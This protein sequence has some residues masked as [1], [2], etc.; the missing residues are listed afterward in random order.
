ML[1]PDYVDYAELRRA[2][3]SWRSAL[4]QRNA[5]AYISS[6]A[7][8]FAPD[9]GDDTNAWKEKSRAFLARSSNVVVE[10]ED[11][12]VTLTEVTRPSMIF[13]QTYRSLN[14]RTAVIKTLHWVRVGDRWLIARES[15]E[16][17]ELSSH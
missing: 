13:K 4:T 5:E 7:P 14:D 6:Y 3:Q 12:S 2:L 15:S 11:L 1:P 10:I 8:D 16:A 9:T 17:P